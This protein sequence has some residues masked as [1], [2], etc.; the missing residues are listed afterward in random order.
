MGLDQIT[1]HNPTGDIR[2]EQLGDDAALHGVGQM[3][4]LARRRISVK[5]SDMVGPRVEAGGIPS[6][7]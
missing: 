2:R 7:A 4:S 3:G 6:R 1:G 5:R